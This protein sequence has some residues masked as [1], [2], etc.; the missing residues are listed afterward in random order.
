MLVKTLNKQDKNLPCMFLF[1]EIVNVLKKK[2]LITLVYLLSGIVVSAQ[3]TNYWS[4]S[5]NSEASLLAGA[6][7]GGNSD[8]TAIYYNPAGIAEIENKKI[9]LNAN[10]FNLSYTN[11]ENALGTGLNL[12]YLSFNVQPRFISYIFKLKKAEKLV[13]QFAIFNRNDKRVSVYDQIE[14]PVQL[15]KPN[16]QEIY[17][18]NLDFVNDYLDSWGGFGLAYKVNKN[19]TIGGSLLFSIKNFAYMN[20]ISINIHPVVESLPDTV[21]YYAAY[22]DNYEKIVSYDVRM[23]GKFGIRYQI[24]RLSIGINL[25]LPSV[26]LF[27]NSDVKRNISNAGI[28]DG[29]EEVEDVYLN[30]S[31]NYLKSGFK[32]PLSISLGL[33]YKN[34]SGKSSYYFTTEYFYKIDTYMA[35]DGTQVV[36]NE[37]EPGT[38]FL[39]YKFGAK[40]IIN[41]AIGWQVQASEKF[42]LLFGFRTNFSSYS[43]SNEGKFEAINEFIDPTADLYHL[44]GGSKFNY[45]KLS[46]IAGLEF[47][48]GRTRELSEFVNFA[49]PAVRP[50]KNLALSGSKNNN[51]TYTNN[52]VGLYFGFTLGF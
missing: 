43:V 20:L 4:V 47:I 9:A 26:R 30:E 10:L 13:W 6:V 33:K 11:Y 19:F 49:E 28:L 50:G 23:L 51:M 42:E 39:S 37:Y 35:I 29:T 40:S 32:D 14:K 12:D 25:S 2:S 38:D 34:L 24:E 44:T 3:P 48:T 45:K 36:G 7:V 17:T 31:V 52:A 27:G 21:N 22:S 18:G 5:F 1:H 15:L 16:I 41:F 8:I 46:V